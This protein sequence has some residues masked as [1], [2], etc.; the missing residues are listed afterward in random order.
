MEGCGNI[1]RSLVISQR[2]LQR[3]K[4]FGIGRPWQ[5]ANSCR[6]FWATCILKKDAAFSSDTPESIY[7]LALRHYPRLGSEWWCVR[8]Y[9]SC[10][11][12][13][14]KWQDKQSKNLYQFELASYCQSWS[15]FS[16]QYSIL[17]Q[18]WIIL[19]SMALWYWNLRNS[20]YTCN[21]MNICPLLS[22]FWQWQIPL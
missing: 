1:M 13:P 20:W 3:S 5:M 9:Y 6:R 17:M 14:F 18:C 2:Y 7:Q 11:T 15:V 21:K 19:I 12:V 16:L 10:W 4:S 8:C 22:W